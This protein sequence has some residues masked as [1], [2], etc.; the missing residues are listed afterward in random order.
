MSHLEIKFW[1]DKDLIVVKMTIKSLHNMTYLKGMHI[2]N[3][4]IY[5]YILLMYFSANLK[6]KELFAI[7][8]CFSLP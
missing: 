5:I 8:G 2:W 4:Y 1:S 3:I 6:A 7:G